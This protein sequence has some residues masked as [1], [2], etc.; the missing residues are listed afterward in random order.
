ED[1][2]QYADYLCRLLRRISYEAHVVKSGQDALRYLRQYPQFRLMT[3]DFGLPDIDGVQVAIQARREGFDIP[4][5]GISGGA[6]YMDENDPDI[7]AAQ[8]VKVIPKT[9]RAAEIARLILSVLGPSTQ[10]QS[11]PKLDLSHSLC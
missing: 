6:K 4:I 1:E 7:K 9:S 3:L 8:F 2:N 10:T 11:G 5:I